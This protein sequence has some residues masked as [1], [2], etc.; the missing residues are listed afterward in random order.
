MCQWIG[1]MLGYCQLNPKEKHQWNFNK[2]KSIHE[3]AYE[4]IVCEMA[5]ISSRG[6]ELKLLTR[7]PNP[8]GQV[9]SS[10]TARIFRIISIIV[11]HISYRKVVPSLCKRNFLK[12]LPSYNKARG[13]SGKVLFRN[14]S[15]RDIFRVTG[16]LCWEFTGDRWI[17]HT[18]ASDAELWS[19]LWSAPE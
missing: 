18:K 5:A 7:D 17:P 3:N 11:Y 6:D 8:G 1:S 2:K 9:H 14:I 19:F 4:N 10:V 15:R 12:V 13:V 16:H